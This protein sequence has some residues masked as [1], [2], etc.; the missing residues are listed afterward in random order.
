MTTGARWGVLYDGIGCIHRYSTHILVADHVY[1]P[2]NTPLGAIA[3][4]KIGLYNQGSY[5]TEDKKEGYYYG[6]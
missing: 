4:E 3:A 6:K 5:H 1:V 2:V